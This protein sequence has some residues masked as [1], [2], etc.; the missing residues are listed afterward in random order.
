MS[1]KRFVSIFFLFIFL[2]T[3]SVFGEVLKL[4]ILIQHYFEHSAENEEISILDFIIKHY[5]SEIDHHHKNDNHHEKL[6]F[7]SID[8]H[9]LQIASLTAAPFVIYHHIEHYSKTKTPSYYQGT[10]PNSYLETIWQ[11]PRF[12]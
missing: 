1:V 8:S 11:P 6:P 4:P 7:K 10:Y 5:G 9:S 3:A 2:S 12:S